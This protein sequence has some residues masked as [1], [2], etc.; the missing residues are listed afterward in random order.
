MKID[1]A[2]HPLILASASP[3]RRAILRDLGLAFEVRPASID[4]R[5]DA[6]LSPEANAE[7]LARRKARTVAAACATGTVI[8]CDT[9]VAVGDTILG[10]PSSEEEARSILTFLSG[11]KQRVISGLCLILPRK[12]IE[13]SGH[14]VTVVHTLPMSARDIDEYIATGE[15]FDKAGAYA[16]Q[17]T[18]DRFIERIEGSFDNVV[19]FPTERFR[20]FVLQL[21]ARLEEGGES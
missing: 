2:L 14:D 19:G 15:C 3:R 4:E 6:G 8:G 1:P 18:G 7:T 20:A 21:S 12:G 10:K 9:L 16:I 5:L 13:L 17:E 11:R